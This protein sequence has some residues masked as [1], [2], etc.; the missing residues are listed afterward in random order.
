MEFDTKALEYYCFAKPKTVARGA[1][2]KKIVKDG[3]VCFFKDNNASV[4]AVAHLDTVNPR[5]MRHS[6]VAKLGDETLYFN[7]FLDDRLGVYTILDVLPKFAV[8]VDVL[9][10][11]GEETG[12]S[13][14]S[15]F[16]TKKQYNWIVSFDRAGEDVVTYCYK[17]TKFENLLEKY[18]FT[19]G[20][21][22]Y[23][24][25]KDMERLKCKGFN[26]GV[27]YENGHTSRAAC[28]IQEYARNLRR[29]LC[30]HKDQKDI[31]LP[32]EEEV[33]PKYNYP[34]YKS[35]DVGRISY[36]EKASR[37]RTMERKCPKC[38]HG[39]LINGKCLICDY[40]HGWSLIGKQTGRLKAGR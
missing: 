29:F 14:Q 6:A 5:S 37:A 40:G 7:P 10:T 18:Q 36:W 33:G 16:E 13:T 35:E 32:H 2:C 8:E 27:G 24:D 3:K 15:A 20:F 1:G 39:Q 31:Y 9:L 26:I 23:S 4:L 21:G 30:F 28:I 17:D 11:L 25:I 34:A 22:S 19:T 12:Q 38:T